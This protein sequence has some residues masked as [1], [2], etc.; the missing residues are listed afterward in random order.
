MGRA[1]R[2]PRR[3]LNRHHTRPA[4]R[5]VCF[6]IRRIAI[7][8]VITSTKMKTGFFKNQVRATIRT[9]RSHHAPV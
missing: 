4:A 7:I 2:S 3:R 9:Q 6:T 8:A 1:A 5:Q